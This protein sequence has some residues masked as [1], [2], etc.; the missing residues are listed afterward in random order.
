MLRQR[1]DYYAENHLD[2]LRVVCEQVSRFIGDAQVVPNVNYI[3]MTLDFQ[4][5]D[6][7]ISQGTSQT[8]SVKVNK[9]THEIRF[10]DETES[11]VIVVIAPKQQS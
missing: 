4:K 10:T 8:V 6:L 7:N 3:P 9:A 1:F 2:T 5:C 11:E